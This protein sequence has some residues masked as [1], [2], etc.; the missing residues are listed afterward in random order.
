MNATTIGTEPL[1][2]Q[3]N[4]GVRHHT[5]SVSRSLDAPPPSVL[6]AFA[7]NSIRRR[8]FK[9][10]GSGAM[11]D[12]DFS[13]G[14]G[15]HAQST[16]KVLDSAPER[17]EYR[18]RYIQIVADQRIVFV[19]ESSVDD[20]LRWTSLTTVLLTED[21][22]ATSLD[23]TEQV[24]FLTGTG[25][26]SADLPHLRGATLLRLNGLAAALKPSSSLRRPS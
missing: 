7:D 8:W 26:G 21:A 5:F 2:A 12:H 23:W 19:Y 14:G 16:F 1:P 17:L 6:A 15:E 11:Y 4:L 9:L 3:P 10:P 25:D 22:G 13:V 18:S 24:A 20:V